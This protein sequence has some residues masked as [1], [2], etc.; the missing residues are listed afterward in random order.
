LALLGCGEQPAS[1][2]ADVRPFLD[3]YCMRCHGEG[4]EGSEASG[5]R[6]DDYESLMKGTAHG[7]VIKPGDSFTSVLVML[8]EGRADPSLRMPHDEGKAPKQAEIE[9]V[10]AWIDQGAK[11]N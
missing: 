5:L 8:V 10:K 6:M 11:D 3:N 7:P 9:R 1:Y 2:S 4:G